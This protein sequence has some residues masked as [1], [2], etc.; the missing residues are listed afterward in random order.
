MQEGRGLWFQ[1]EPK[2]MKAMPLKEMPALLQKGINSSHNKGTTPCTPLPAQAATEAPVSE[3]PTGTEGSGH[4]GRSPLRPALRPK[5]N[6]DL[7]GKRRNH[8]SLYNCFHI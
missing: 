6:G 3:R 2:K 1:G 4:G 5:L 8:D 7:G